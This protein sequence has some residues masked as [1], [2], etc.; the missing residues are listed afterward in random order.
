MLN[1]TST[2]GRA[3]LAAVGLIA[4][5]AAGCGDAGF[6]PI[7]RQG[8]TLT[9][10]VVDLERVSELRYTTKSQERDLN[11]FR[12]VPSRG[13][14]EVVALRIRVIN[15]TAIKT[16]VTLDQEA[17]ILEDFF[18]GVYVPVDIGAVGEVWTQSGGSTWGWL[19]NSMAV[20][21][22]IYGIDEDVP[23]PPGWDD[24]PVRSIQ[25]QGKKAKPGEGFLAG[26]IEIEQGKSIDGWMVFEAP[27][28]TEFKE[29]RW[30]AVDSI[31]IPF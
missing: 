17:A 8:N 19:S 3:F 30:R 18:D 13:G 28:G 9:I 5:L 16:I 23:E 24:S 11:H 12:F 25:L 4:L 6:Q 2:L 29:L 26:S 14:A 31:L 21:M 22:P 7:I 10:T 20:D 15:D 27:E 1:V